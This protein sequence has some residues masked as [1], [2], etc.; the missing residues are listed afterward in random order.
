M[1][2]KQVRNNKENRASTDNTIIA[3]TTT[4]VRPPLLWPFAHQQIQ[5]TCSQSA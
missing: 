5:P 4:I 1:S 3:P 2:E